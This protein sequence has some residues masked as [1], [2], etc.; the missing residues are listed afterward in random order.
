MKKIKKYIIESIREYTNLHTPD[1]NEDNA[2]ISDMQYDFNYNEVK[3]AADMVSQLIYKGSNYRLVSDISLCSNGE[4]T[5]HIYD[6]NRY[7][8]IAQFYLEF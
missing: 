7:K 1:V 6:N 4:L 2:N 8:E 5:I 3:A